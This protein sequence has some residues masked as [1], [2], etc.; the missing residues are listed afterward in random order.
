MI[1]ALASIADLGS[2]RATWMQCVIILCTT[3]LLLRGEALYAKQDQCDMPEISHHHEKIKE[4]IA[5]FRPSQAMNHADSL[6]MLD[7]QFDLGNCYSFLRAKVDAMESYELKQTFEYPLEIYHQIIQQ[8]QKEHFPDIIAECYISIARIHEILGRPIDCKRNLENAGELISAHNLQKSNSRFSI[9]LASYHRIYDDQVLAKKYASEAILL[10]KEYQVPRSEIDGH[11]L[12]GILSTELAEAINHFRA[13]VRLYIDKKHYYGAAAQNLNIARR[14]FSAGQ[15]EKSN[16]FVD[17]SLSLVKYID[18]DVESFHNMMAGSY[19]IKN[20]IFKIQGRLDSA[21]F[22]KTKSHEHELQSQYETNQATINEIEI[23]NAV[24][25]ELEKAAQSNRREKILR[26]FSIGTVILLLLLS[27]LLLAL[28]KK[29]N[30]VQSKN[31][32]ILSKNNQL[33]AS[34]KKQQVLLS[35]IHHRVKNNLQVIIGLITMKANHIN[36]EEDKIYLNDLTNKIQSIALIH[37]QLYKS[38]DFKLISLVDYINKLFHHLN[39]LLSQENKFAYTL[40]IE[41]HALNLETMLPLGIICTELNSNSL[42]YGHQPNTD[43]QISLSIKKTSDSNYLLHYRDNGP[44]F[45][46][47]KTNNNKGIGTVLIESMVRQLKGKMKIYN[48]KGA[49]TEVRFSEKPL[50]EL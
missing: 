16:A 13:A 1:S 50:S 41:E 19:R 14:Y 5:A 36:K 42:K 30:E 47:E 25:N 43:L 38:H 26:T 4:L 46:D 44:G 29:R 15:Y 49:V 35:E 24:K 11:L 3:I 28:Y 39:Q 21:Y 8:A 27:F 20:E 6:T 12:M 45:V 37:E 17:S 22:Y 7:K 10:G 2:S 34:V 40:D 32:L 48:D 33:E 31:L 23:K 9:R 18:E